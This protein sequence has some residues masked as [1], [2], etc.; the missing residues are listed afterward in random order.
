[1]M[2]FLADSMLGKLA[3]WLRLL[4]Y[5]TLY[6]RDAE[7]RELV[8][9][10]LQEDRVLLTRDNELAGRR[11]VRDRTLFIDSQSTWSQL[12]QV[13]RHFG[14]ESE[15]SLFT[16]CLVCNAVLEDIPKSS[17]EGLVPPYVYQTQDRFQRC[18][19]CSRIYWRGTHVEHVMDVLARESDFADLDGNSDH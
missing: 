18:P 7:D 10:A 4:G 1:M 11:M 17:V 13:I 5:D 16:R 9:I 14:L 8:R 6:Q 12:R 19:S 3:K 15:N 2:K